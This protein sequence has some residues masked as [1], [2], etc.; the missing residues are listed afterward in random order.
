[1]TASPAAAPAQPDAELL[2]IEND[3]NLNAVEKARK[4]QAHINAKF[5]QQLEDEEAQDKVGAELK[6]AAV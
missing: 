1:M 6:P 2:A 5:L 3:P 4:R